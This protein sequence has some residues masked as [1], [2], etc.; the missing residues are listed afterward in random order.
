MLHRHEN[1]PS[2]LAAAIEARMATPFAW[3]RH[4]CCMA[5]VALIEAM[6][7]A[8]LGRSYRGYRSERGA[9]ARLG[10]HG[11][12]AAIAQAMA[13]EHAIAAIDPAHA[14]RGDVVLIHD[15]GADH[16]GVVD[17]SGRTAL[18]VSKIG[19]RGFP[20]SAAHQ[21]WRVG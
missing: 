15:N 3:G 13:A 9:R 4:D 7:G 5:A 1:W 14:Q 18:V 16:L 6:T 21:A 2:R 10:R 19:W 11:G 20:I 12:V 17:S 8:D